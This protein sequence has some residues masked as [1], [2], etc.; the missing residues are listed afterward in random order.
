MSKSNLI[1]ISFTY[2]FSVLLLLLTFKE[3]LTIF[4]LLH[5]SLFFLFIS[6]LIFK[7][8][9]TTELLKFSFA[10]KITYIRLTISILL[11]TASITSSIDAAIFRIFYYESAFIIL[12]PISLLLDGLDGFIA[13]KY[14]DTSKFGELFDQESDNFLMFVLSI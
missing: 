5:N 4:I 9:S 11:L 8:F 3:Q 12:A 1:T 2:L 13:R 7:F 6:Y 14:N 10:S